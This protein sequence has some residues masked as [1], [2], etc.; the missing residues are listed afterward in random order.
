VHFFPAACIGTVAFCLLIQKSVFLP[1][2]N[3]AASPYSM[4]LL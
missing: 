1:S 3:P 4:L 2:L